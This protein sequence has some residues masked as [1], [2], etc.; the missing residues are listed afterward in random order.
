MNCVNASSWRLGVTEPA[1]ILI[2]IKRL[3]VSTIR[4]ISAKVTVPLQIKKCRIGQNVAQQGRLPDLS[5]SKHRYGRKMLQQVVDGLLNI[6]SQI[7][8]I[9][10]PSLKLLDEYGANRR[11]RMVILHQPKRWNENALPHCASELLD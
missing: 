6:P 4:S 2:G 8:H 11:I 7:R 3:S 10:S 9:Q 5:C 1:L